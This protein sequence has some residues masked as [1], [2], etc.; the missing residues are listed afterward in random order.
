MVPYTADGDGV[1]VADIPATYKIT[2]G[3]CLATYIS[4]TPKTEWAKLRFMFLLDL[5]MATD[6]HCN[7]DCDQWI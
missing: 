2:R 3:E 1:F 7:D 4:L 6:I 5:S